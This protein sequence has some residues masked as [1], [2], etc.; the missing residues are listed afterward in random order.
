[1]ELNCIERILMM[2]VF[3]SIVLAAILFLS[4]FKELNPE[5]PSYEANIGC[6]Y[7]HETGVNEIGW[8][9]DHIWE[10]VNGDTCEYQCLSCFHRFIVFNY[11]CY[12][13]E[14][15]I[16]YVKQLGYDYPYLDKE[17]QQNGSNR[18]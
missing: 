15:F 16:K 2:I 5:L 6:P 7:C 12:E 14:R 17:E 13:K 9:V 10:W 4:G 1:M 3:I 18:K 11:K 8:V